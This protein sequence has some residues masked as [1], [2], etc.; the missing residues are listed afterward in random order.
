V[1]NRERERE[2]D[3][4]RETERERERERGGA[5]GDK[6]GTHFQGV[7]SIALNSHA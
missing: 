2:R 7:R 1:R 6:V 4:Q 5:V 3:R